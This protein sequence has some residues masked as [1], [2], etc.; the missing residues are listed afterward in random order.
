[1]SNAD[2]SP[3]VF[4]ISPYHNQ[5]NRQDDQIKQYIVLNNLLTNAVLFVN[6]QFLSFYNNS[7]FAP[8]KSR[9]T[10]MAA[11]LFAV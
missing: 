8:L 10:M 6:I 11:I 4:G 3:R 5:Q 7:S 2:N 9:E 1:M